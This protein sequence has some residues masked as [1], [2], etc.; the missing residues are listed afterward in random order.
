MTVK[1]CVGPCGR[2]LEVNAENFYRQSKGRDSFQ[3][4]CK[5]CFK[6]QT[7]ERAKVRYNTD[8]EYRQKVIDRNAERYHSNPEY[9]ASRV[10]AA[11]KRSQQ[12]YDEDPEGYARYSKAHY[13]VKRL[14]GPASTHL[15]ACGC[16]KQAQDWAL[17]NDSQNIE[18]SKHY[19]WSD[20]VSDYMPMHRSCHKNY[21]N[22]RGFGEEA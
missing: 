20:V 2:T 18:T 21:D 8:E 10:A 6:R 13:Q 5:E 4:R 11:V 1:T 15:C 22:G 12:R 19:K 9:R 7:T 16:G 3:S 14:N 17:K